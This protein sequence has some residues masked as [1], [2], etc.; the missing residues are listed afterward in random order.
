MKSGNSSQSNPKYEGKQAAPHADCDG[1]RYIN[2][3]STSSFQAFPPDC[4]KRRCL[5]ALVQRRPAH[6]SDATNMVLT[7]FRLFSGQGSC[8]QQLWFQ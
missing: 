6:L 4:T 5:Q 7:E 8:V 1:L 3:A 2:A